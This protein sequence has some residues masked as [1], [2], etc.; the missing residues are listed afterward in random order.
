MLQ[1]IRVL[2][3]STTLGVAPLIYGFFAAVNG[4]S[5][6]WLYLVFN[7]TRWIVLT[8]VASLF[9]PSIAF[10]LLHLLGSCDSQFILKLTGE[11]ISESSFALIMFTFNLFGCTVGAM[12][13]FTSTRQHKPIKLNRVAR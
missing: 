3:E 2:M 12:H 10:M 6:A 11:S 4:Y 5:A 1:L 8:L 13:A 7:G 9:C